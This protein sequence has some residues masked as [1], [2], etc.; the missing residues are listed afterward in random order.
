MIALIP[1]SE[2]PSR[3]SPDCFV[4]TGTATILAALAAGGAGITTAKLQSNAAG[5]AANTATNAANYAA[6]LQADANAATL[7]FNQ[8]QADRD[9]RNA[10][11]IQRA[12]YDQWAAN[13][14]N[15]YGQGVAN[16]QNSY[17]AAVAG[18]H[19]T[20]NVYAAQQGRVGQ[21]GE[22]LGMGPRNIPKYEDLPPLVVPDLKIPG[23]A[24]PGATSTTTRSGQNF[25]P[26][27]IG[28]QVTSELAKY[29]VRPSARGSGPGDVAN[30][31]DYITKSA[32]GWEP[33]WA[34]RI[35]QEVQK[36]GVGSGYQSNAGSLMN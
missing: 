31:V 6:K 4:A 26:S 30:W 20:Y 14:Q 24:G 23:Y 25:D 2:N 35:K 3:E 9:Q 18:G 34:D 28:Q 17:N 19:N 27:Y 16:S 10:E 8:E 29:G 36:A 11:Q 1:S 15:L 13:T 5:K 12:N 32:N 7:K 21:L 33:Y 22:L